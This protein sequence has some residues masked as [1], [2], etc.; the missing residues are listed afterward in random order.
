MKTK[1]SFDH[2]SFQKQLDGRDKGKSESEYKENFKIDQDI[3]L[4]LQKNE[5]KHN[6]IKN[7]LTEI[8]AAYI[9]YKKVLN[10][11]GIQ[12]KTKDSTSEKK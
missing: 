1:N 12:S 3:I 7:P 6:K 8:T 10:Q 2:L 11:V 9:R 5:V 4:K